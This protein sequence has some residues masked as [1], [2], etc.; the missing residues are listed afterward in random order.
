MGMDD[1]L[2]A[3]QADVDRFVMGHLRRSQAVVIG[4]DDALGAPQADVDSPPHPGG[5]HGLAQCPQRS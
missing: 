2:G 5:S 1:D 4:L 3:P